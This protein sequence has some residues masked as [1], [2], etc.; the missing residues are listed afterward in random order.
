MVDLEVIAAQI[1]EDVLKMDK[2]QTNYEKI[3]SIGIDEMAEFLDNNFCNRYYCS[4]RERVSTLEW[5]HQKAN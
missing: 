1:R 5:L 4:E 2:K 3:T